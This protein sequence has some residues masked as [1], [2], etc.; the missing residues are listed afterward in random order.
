[1]SEFRIT[2]H[3]GF[4]IDFEN[5]W[6]I[7]VQFGAGNYCDNHDREFDFEKEMDML[8][9]TNAEIGI[10]N[11]KDELIRHPDY[12]SKDTVK[13]WVTPDELVHFINWTAEQE[14]K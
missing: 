13:G 14:G 4:Q 8:K 11:P 5:G 10:F 12:G 2:R 7:S 3:K 1:M 9:S 6:C